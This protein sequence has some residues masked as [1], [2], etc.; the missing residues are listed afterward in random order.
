MLYNKIN[1]IRT[2]LGFTEKQISSLLNI[3][4]YKY[5]RYEKG[6][7]DISTEILLLLSIMYHIP[8]DYLFFSRYSVKA[9]KEHL[10]QSSFFNCPQNNRFHI[11]ERNLYE[12]SDISSSK[13][14]IKV[15]QNILNTHKAFLGTNLYN[16]RLNRR[17]ELNEL[18]N[19][20]GI[21][22]K[23]Y[24]MIENSSMFPS[25]S[26]LQ[27][28]SEVLEIEIYKLFSINDFDSK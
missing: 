7:F 17:V 13:I 12:H 18:C 21:S 28:V 24:L 14:N 19:S 27:I 4:C 2:Y 11:L 25:V 9:I 23:E 26:Q 3:S 5:R 1:A 16:I 10:D 8:I 20:L 15:I 6:N 22:A